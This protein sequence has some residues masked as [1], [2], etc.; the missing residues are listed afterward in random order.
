[1]ILSSRGAVLEALVKYQKGIGRGDGMDKSFLKVSVCWV[2][3]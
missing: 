3:T 2:K 1:M